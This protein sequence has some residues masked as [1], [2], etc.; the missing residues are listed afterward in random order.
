MESTGD[1]EFP[2]VKNSEIVFY[3]KNTRH[4]GKYPKLT[5]KIRYIEKNF[6]NKQNSTW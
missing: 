3:A 4:V 6:R 2:L 1:L 5:E